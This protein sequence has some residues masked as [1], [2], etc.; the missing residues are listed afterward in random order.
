MVHKEDAMSMFK[1]QKDANKNGTFVLKKQGVSW[2]SGLA[3][4]K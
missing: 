3:P 4:T 2:G 1:L